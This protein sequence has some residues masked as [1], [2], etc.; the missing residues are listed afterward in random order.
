MRRIQAAVMLAII[1]AALSIPAQSS[2]AELEGIPEK[3]RVGGLG[4]YIFSFPYPSRRVM[5]N[6]VVE[7]PATVSGAVTVSLAVWGV[8]LDEP[9]EIR[10][11]GKV[12]K[13][14]TEPGYYVVS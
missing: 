11:D 1:A 3:W 10:L 13:K 7:S 8:S 9:V 14:I 12:I 4:V 2:L 5:N 6:T